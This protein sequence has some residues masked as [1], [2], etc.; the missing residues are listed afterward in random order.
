MRES[1][2]RLPEETLMQRCKELGL[3]YLRSYVEDHKT[4]VCFECE[5]HRYLGE[6][7]SAWTHFR[8]A[9]YGCK[10]CAG[11]CK[12]SFELQSELNERNVQVTIL[13]EYISARS[14]ILYRCNLCGKEFSAIPN[15]LLNGQACPECGKKRSSLKRTKTTDDFKS[16]LLAIQ[17]NIEIVGDYL[18][19]HKPIKCR[20]KIDGYTWESYPANLLNRSAGCAVCCNAISKGETIIKNYLDDKQID[21]KH[22]YSMPGCRRVNPLRFDFYIPS[23]K[24]AIEFD[25]RQ[26]YEEVP[27]FNSSTSTLELT[28][29]RDG[30]KDAYC[31]E[32]GIRMI[33]IPHYDIRKIEEIL[34]DELYR[35]TA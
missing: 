22:E 32:H 15:S 7:R 31:R 14:K 20:C 17:P 3:V 8:S 10:Y 23:L 18:G 34:N 9:K 29:E 6:Q 30:I 35:D 26:H 1:H 24:A 4:F 12:T 13:G 5:K 28:R 27:Y 21:Y 19:S 16:D 2:N 25:G 11:K 33:R